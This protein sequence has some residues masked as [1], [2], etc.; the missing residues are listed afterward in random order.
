MSSIFGN[1]FI[2][3]TIKIRK[4]F[5][6]FMIPIAL[7]EKFEPVLKAKQQMV[8][9]RSRQTACLS[10]NPFIDSYAALSGCMAMVQVYDSVMASI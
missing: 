10:F 7:L 9:N 6:K 8:G 1:Q 5:S 3:T 4:G 2:V